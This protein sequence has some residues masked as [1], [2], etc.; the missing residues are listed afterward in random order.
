M[1]RQLTINHWIHQW[2]RKQFRQWPNGAYRNWQMSSAL[3][4]TIALEHWGYLGTSVSVRLCVCVCDVSGP[5]LQTI[6]KHWLQSSP[7]WL[8]TICNVQFHCQSKG[9]AVKLAIIRNIYRLIIL[10]KYSL[11]TNT[12]QLTVINVAKRSRFVFRLQNYLVRLRWK[13]ALWVKITRAILLNLQY[14]MWVES[15][16]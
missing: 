5:T 1:P 8:T 10:S 7:L 6:P 13:N 4:T 2:V 14:V 16:M 3:S 12:S 11:L 9:S 15:F